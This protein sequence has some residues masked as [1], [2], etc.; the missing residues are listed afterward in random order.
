MHQPVNLMLF[1]K[2]ADKICPEHARRARHEN[3][4][5]EDSFN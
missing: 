1:I 2:L 5:G 4:H 3:F